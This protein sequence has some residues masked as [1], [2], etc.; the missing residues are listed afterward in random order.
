MRTARC[1]VNLCPIYD[2]SEINIL[3]KK[4]RPRNWWSNQ[5]SSFSSEY[6]M[7]WK[8]TAPFFLISECYALLRNTF[9]RKSRT[10]IYKVHYCI[11]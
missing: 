6:V 5:L 1:T 9:T 8:C 11:N 2:N 7:K 10:E 4:K 3:N